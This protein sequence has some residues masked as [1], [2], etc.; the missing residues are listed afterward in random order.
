MAR[1]FAKGFYRSKSWKHTREAYFNSVHGLCERCR[2]QGVISK[3]EIVHHKE[4]LTPENINNPEIALGF[5]NLELLCRPCH[6]EEHPEIYQKENDAQPLRVAFDENGD[7]IN[8]EVK[9]LDLWKNSK[10]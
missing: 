3:G 6:A 5:D 1:E 2:A 8:L 7:L 4:H 9:E 10:V